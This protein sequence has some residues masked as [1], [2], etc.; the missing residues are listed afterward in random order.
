MALQ[1]AA[2][3]LLMDTSFTVDERR[4]FFILRLTR[5]SGHECVL[6]AWDDWTVDRVLTEW[7]Q[8]TGHRR[9]LGM[10]LLCQ[11]E[12]V[13]NNTPVL[14]WLGIGLRGELSDYQ[15]LFNQPRLPSWWEPQWEPYV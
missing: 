9:V 6:A 8:K 5:M 12:R 4:N 2:D 10:Q 13:P 7:C 1:Y 14:E 3:Q 11:A 15:L